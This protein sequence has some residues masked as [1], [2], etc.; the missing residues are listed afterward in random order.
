MGKEIDLVPSPGPDAE[1]GPENDILAAGEVDVSMAGL[2]RPP[3]F[4]WSASLGIEARRSTEV[5]RAIYLICFS[6]TVFLINERM[7]QVIGE[8]LG[9][10][11]SFKS[12]VIPAPARN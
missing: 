2:D 6:A 9:T 11:G 10:F 7:P 8:L 1:M 12:N 4:T 5:V 3:H